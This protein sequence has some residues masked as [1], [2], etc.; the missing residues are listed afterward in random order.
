MTALTGEK[1]L[2]KKVKTFSHWNDPCYIC[3][4]Q[5]GR[6]RNCRKTACT[7]PT[8]C[9]KYK[10]VEGKCCKYI[11]LDNTESNSFGTHQPIF[12]ID[13]YFDLSMW[14][15]LMTTVSDMIHFQSQG[16][17][18]QKKGTVETQILIVQRTKC[19]NNIILM[20]LQLGMGIIGS[21]CK[22]YDTPLRDSNGNSGTR[23]SYDCTDWRERIIKEGQNFQPRNDPCYIC[24]CQRGRGRNCRKT[25]C[26]PPTNCRKYKNV[27]GKCCEYICLDNTESNSFGT[28]QPSANGSSNAKRRFDCTDWS[29]KVIKE[30]QRFQPRYD[31]CYLCSCRK[32]NG[33]YCRATECRPPSNC[34]NY[35]RIEGKCCKFNC[36]DNEERNSLDLHRPG[37]DTDDDLFTLCSDDK[38]FPITEF[39]C[40]L[41]RWTTKPP[42]FCT[43]Q[44]GNRIK[45]GETFVPKKNNFCM[46]CSC[47]RGRPS[48]CMSVQCLPPRNCTSYVTVMGKCCK[49]VCKDQ[50]SDIKSASITQD[51]VWLRGVLSREGKFLEKHIDLTKAWINLS[52]I[53]YADGNVVEEGQTV[54]SLNRN[55]CRKCRCVN[56]KLQRCITIPC[57]PP[58]NCKDYERLP[59]GCCHYKCNDNQE[60]N[61]VP[62]RNK[63]RAATMMTWKFQDLIIQGLL[64]HLAANMYDMTLYNV[65]V[66]ILKK[67]VIALACCNECHKRYL[68]MDNI[69]LKSTYILI[70]RIYRLLEIDELT[71]E[72]AFELADSIDRAHKKSCFMGREATIINHHHQPV[73]A[74]C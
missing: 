33:R 73:P 4:C 47:V 34:R 6:S 7:P 38:C 74:Y 70:G 68:P 31:P 37:G 45:E 25:A 40:S 42:L 58:S 1:E 29:G 17:G 66:A 20:Q 23:A 55:S 36:L 9:R 48:L 18:H 32:G 2:S 62:G 26:T 69:L 16:Q 54:A 57:K 63:M 49:F 21:T 64:F 27:E 56:G 71:L 8:N 72:K 30:N 53:S 19:Q 50:T 22:W 28:H 65:C 41:I 10:N 52:L 12:V 35:Q 44:D 51:R 43:D 3:A 59:G 60:S 39:L 15:P 24:A 14:H 11:C 46:K 5:R 13:C 61:A 67:C